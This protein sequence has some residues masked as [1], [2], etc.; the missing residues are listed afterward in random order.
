MRQPIFDVRD[1]DERRPAEHGEST[2][3][4][5]NRIA[6]AYWEQPRALVQQWADNI[7]VTAEYNEVRQRLRSR[8]NDQFRSAFLELYL[9][10]SLLRAGYAL[11]FHPE[12]PG[13]SRKPD[14]LAERDGGRLYVEATAPGTAAE[15]KAAAGRSAVLLDTVNGLQ[16]PNFMLWLESLQEGD[17]PPSSARL[18]EDVRNWLDALDPDAITDIEH[19]PLWRWTHGG[20][21]V[22]FRPLP[23]RVEARGVRPGDRSIGVY[24]QSEA[25]IV[26]DAPAIRAALAKKHHAYGDLDAPFVIAVGTY[27]FDTERWHSTNAMYGA[28]G[29]NFQQSATGEILTQEIRQPGGYFGQPPNWQ[30]RNVSGVLLV[31]QLMPYMVPRVEATLWL[32]PHPVHP[33]PSAAGFAAPALAFDGHR[34]METPPILESREFFGLPDPWPAGDPWPDDD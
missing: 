9:H 30:H 29:V 19:A 7:R 6:G 34:L 8:D 5:L 11:Q 17:A 32:H 22:A 3:A 10:E 18:R 26:D 20:W 31:N 25:S 13:T 16:H 21:S 1:R 28:L 12:V 24:G 27:I 4:F 2:F 15:A 14:F 23:K 33:L